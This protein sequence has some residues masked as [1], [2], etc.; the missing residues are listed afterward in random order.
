MEDLTNQT[1]DLPPRLQEL[2]LATQTVIANALTLQ[3]E[4]ND[5][6]DNPSKKIAMLHRAVG[7]LDKQSESCFFGTSV[8][9]EGNYEYPMVVVDDG[10][11]TIKA[12]RE[13]GIRR[14]RSLGFYGNVLPVLDEAG[15][16][17]SDQV[18]I[19][20]SHGIVMADMAIG[21]RLF[22]LAGSANVNAPVSTSLLVPSEIEDYR[23]NAL[24]EM[25]VRQTKRD[26]RWTD[27]FDE[28]LFQV[29][30]TDFKAL[31]TRLSRLRALRVDRVEAYL[32]YIN[33]KLGV[34]SSSAEIICDT[35]LVYAPGQQIPYVIKPVELVHGRNPDI[36]FAPAY[37]IDNASG[38]VHK[39]VKS[40]PTL[41]LRA[42]IEG[43]DGEHILH[44][45]L[46]SIQHAEFD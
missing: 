41:S 32:T 27:T 13:Y 3:S 40:T 25:F 39:L 34:E 14:G 24:A 26:S 35:L 4:I 6:K 30:G 28:A 11:F 33:S 21:N 38:L 10:V 17:E 43:Q 1:I 42:A 16:P 45:P 20:I 12:I 36:S 46:S 29:N 7:T 19:E 31:S 18:L 15:E 22:K 9:I 2:H 44:I 23:N 8:Q 37:K 5:S